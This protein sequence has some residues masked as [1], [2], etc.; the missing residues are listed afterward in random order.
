MALELRFLGQSGLRLACDGSALYIDPCLTDSVATGVPDPE[1]WRRAFPA[2]IAATDVTDATAVLVTHEHADHLDLET[3]GPLAKASPTAPFVMPWAAA[4]LAREQLDESRIVLASGD[5]DEHAFGPFTVA[6]VPAAH[7]AAYTT[8]R[9]PK[10]H[11]WLGYLVEAA[12]C[13]I[14]HAGDTVRFDDQV[15]AVTARGPIDIAVLPINGRDHARERRDV[16]GN[17]WPREAADLAV[18]L[19]ARILVPL[20]HDLFAYNGIPAGQLVDDVVA[21]RLPLEVRVLV[22]GGAT[23]IAAR[24]DGLANPS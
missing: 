23:D 5:A 9:G 16:V 4:T 22:A 12:G 21:R 17:L 24:G 7:S 15:P 3:L 14:Y 19:G 8:E 11:R 1:L 10:G 2:P 6:A 13:R 20:H 18:D